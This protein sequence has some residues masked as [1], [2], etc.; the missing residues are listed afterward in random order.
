[1]KYWP[2]SQEQE[3]QEAEAKQIWMIIA[4]VVAAFPAVVL[5]AMWIYNFRSKRLIR[6]R[7]QELIEIFQYH[8]IKLEEETV[9]DSKM[10]DNLMIWDQEM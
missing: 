4:A 8:G 1:M 5:L 6:V 10:L 3:R 9:T 2:K 7:R